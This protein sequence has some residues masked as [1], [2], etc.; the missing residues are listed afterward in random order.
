MALDVLVGT[1]AKVDINWRPV[2]TSNN[3]VP[4]RVLSGS[5]LDEAELE[6]TTDTDTRFGGREYLSDGYCVAQIQMTI[7]LDFKPPYPST[8]LY[9]APYALIPG[10]IVGLRIWPQGRMGNTLTAWVFT[11]AIIKSV[12]TGFTVRGTQP[13]GG[14]VSIVSYSRYKRPYETYAYT[15]SAPPSETPFVED[16]TTQISSPGDAVNGDPN[17]M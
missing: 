15:T 13:Y 2:T 5:I 10:Y 9:A 6:E 4:F 14:Q 17:L 11:Y 1:V 8:W 7:Q 3:F 16:I 12:G